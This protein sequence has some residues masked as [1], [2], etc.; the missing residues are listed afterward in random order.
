MLPLWI[1]HRRVG[2]E[3]VNRRLVSTTYGIRKVLERYGA[4]IGEGGVFSGPL[5]IENAVGD[6]GNLTI[7][8]NVHIGR[9]VLLDLT[10]P[11]VIEDEAVI[12]MG[13]TLLT[14]FSVGARPLAARL[15][16]RSAPLRIALGAY[17]GANATVLVGCDIGERAVVGAG[18]VVT[19]PIAAES[20]VGGVPARPLM[21]G[22]S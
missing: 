16:E 6:Y 5:I 1:E 8:R 22:V 3:A 19:R 2:I 9:N 11:L 17:I 12:S 4:E 15:P 13:T 21:V 20:V 14:H 10:Q 7:G 18:A